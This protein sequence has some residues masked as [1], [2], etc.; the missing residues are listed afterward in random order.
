[1]DINSFKKEFEENR[2]QIFKEFIEGKIIQKILNKEPK[3]LVDLDAPSLDFTLT[4]GSSKFDW[5]SIDTIELSD[6]RGFD[7]KIS[8]RILLDIHLNF[9]DTSNRCLFEKDKTFRLTCYGFFSS[10]ENKFSYEILTKL[11][12]LLETINHEIL[13]IYKKEN[14]KDIEPNTAPQIDGKNTF[15][16]FLDVTRKSRSFKVPINDFSF[17]DDLVR[18]TIDIKFLLA[19]MFIHKPFLWDFLSHRFETSGET[20]FYYYP[21]YHDLRY[22]TYCDLLFQTIYNYWD[23]IGGLLA[24][25]FLPDRKERNIYFSSVI[26]SI[27]LS[28]HSSENLLWLKIFRNDQYK[29]LNEKRRQTVHYNSQSSGFHEQ[30]IKNYTNEEKIAKLQYEIQNLT[31]YFNEHLNYAIIGFEKTL[32]LID[33]IK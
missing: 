19:N 26:D 13:D 29:K 28:Y 7:Y 23:K 24:L 32:R 1:M 2:F 6:V 3:F 17:F 9:Y 27:P 4:I 30:W 33:E 5:S 22:M 10:E 11:E 12:H 21:S 25:Y 15:E 18:K 16:F 20:N 14:L 31:E 8:L